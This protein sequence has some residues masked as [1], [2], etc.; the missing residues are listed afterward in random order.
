MGWCRQGG[1]DSVG[2]DFS[3]NRTS[4]GNSL[5]L[6]RS[7]SPLGGETQ[8]IFESIQDVPRVRRRRLMSSSVDH[9]RFLVSLRTKS[10][11]P[12]FVDMS[13]LRLL[14]MSCASLGIRSISLA[15]G[16]FYSFAPKCPVL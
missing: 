10:D 16:R 9:L 5:T 1:E 15:L 7:Q 14:R 12:S 3:L 13:V 11:S 2:K 4:K 6:K 8:F